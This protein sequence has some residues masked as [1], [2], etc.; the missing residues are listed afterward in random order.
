QADGPLCIPL[1]LKEG[2][3]AVEPRASDDLVTVAQD[4][5]Q[6]VGMQTAAER[7]DRGEA[8]PPRAGRRGQDASAGD[9]LQQLTHGGAEVLLMPLKP[10]APTVVEILQR[11]AQAEDA[12]DVGRARFEAVRQRPEHIPTH[13]DA[14]DGPA[15]E[16]QRCQSLQ[17]LPPP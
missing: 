11:S 1:S 7:D 2:V 8:D 12:T 9:A 13:G 17:S 16:Y 14:I 6:H 3:G 10:V 15:A 4:A 5:A